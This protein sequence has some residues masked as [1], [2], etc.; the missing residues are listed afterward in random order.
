MEGGWPVEVEASIYVGVGAGAGA[1]TG[2]TTGGGTG[3]GTGG[4]LFLKK[5]DTDF[6]FIP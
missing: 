6:F 3:G 4:S 1:G 2:A 5:R